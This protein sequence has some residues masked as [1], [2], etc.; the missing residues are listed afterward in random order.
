VTYRFIAD[1]VVLTHFAFIVF[2]AVGGLLA[3]RWPRTLWLHVPAVAWGLGIVTVG[4]ECPLTPLEKYFRRRGGEDSYDGG[5]VDRYLEDVIYPDRY[6]P[7][8]R[9]V[10]GTLIVVG[11]AGVVVRRRHPAPPPPPASGTDGRLWRQVDRASGKRP[12]QDSN[13]GPAA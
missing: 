1:A 8:L 2:V 3:W 9:A 11:W 10:A 7:L 13:P 5:F 4:Y 12:R 6:T